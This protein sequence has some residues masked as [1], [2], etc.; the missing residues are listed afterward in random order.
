MPAFPVVGIV[1]D[2]AEPSVV[3]NYDAFVRA[4]EFLVRGHLLRRSLQVGCFESYRGEQS[5]YR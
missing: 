4:S 3:S 5:H 1:G 2:G